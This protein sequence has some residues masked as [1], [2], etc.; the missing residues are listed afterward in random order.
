MRDESDLRLGFD[1]VLIRST[2]SLAPSRASIDLNELATPQESQ[3]KTKEE[4][5]ATRKPERILS[6]CH[7]DVGKNG[8]LIVVRLGKHGVLDE[9]TVNEISDELLGVADRP[10]CHRLLLDFS[11][12]AYLSSAM[13]AKLVRLHRKM[14]PEGEKL[15]LC[16]MNSHLRSVFTTTRLDRLFDITDNAADALKAVVPRSPQ[17]P[18]EAI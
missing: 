1:D 3:V 2:R 14:V 10:D 15:R 4:P 9:L 12:V 6:D 16:G 8:D 17:C 18:E 7:L 13:L 11:G 5:V